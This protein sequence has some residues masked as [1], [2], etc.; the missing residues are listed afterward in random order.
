MSHESAGKSNEWYTPL[1]V[2]NSMSAVFDMDVAA[3]V[4]RKH[5]HVPAHHYLTDNGL[6][7]E[8]KGFVWMN[9]PYGRERDK[10]QWLDKFFTHGNGIALMPDR[11]SATWWQV[12][13][14]ASDAILMVHGK[15]KFIAPDGTRGEQP[16]N[17]TTLFGIGSKAV[18]AL[19]RAQKNGLGILFKSI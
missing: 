13:A 5:C 3:P 11:S 9:P 14:E 7:T 6:G 12:S 15:I 10:M 2:F 19:K 4:D 18:S 8:W 1:Y 17:G 16:S